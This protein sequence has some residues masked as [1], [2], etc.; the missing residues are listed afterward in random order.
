[1]M[2][3]IKPSLASGTY[4]IIRIEEQITLVVM[5]AGSTLKLFV[6]VFFFKLFFIFFILI[7]RRRVIDAHGLRLNS[8][9]ALWAIIILD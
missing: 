3:L 2:L 7:I 6:A 1:M 5:S 8:F 4:L 9:M